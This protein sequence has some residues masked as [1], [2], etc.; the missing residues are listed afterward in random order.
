MAPG[1]VNLALS[2]VGY[3]DDVVSAMKYVFGSTFVCEGK[4]LICCAARFAFNLTYNLDDKTANQI[5]FDPQ[6]RIKSV[7]LQGDVYDPSGTLQGGS[8]PSSSGLL[9]KMQR[10][11]E[12]KEALLEKEKELNII[13]HNLKAGTEFNQLKGSW[14]LKKH[15]L[16]LL[17]EQVQSSPCSQVR[18]QFYYFYRISL[19]CYY[20]LDRCSYSNPK[21]PVG[22]LGAWYRR[23]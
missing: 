10:L 8:K 16:S 6:I 13:Q 5:T 23:V 21:G 4:E 12:L 7:T 9:L 1:K 18:P 14:D 19:S 2:L 22:V 11:R 20:I 15:E 17:E 3:D